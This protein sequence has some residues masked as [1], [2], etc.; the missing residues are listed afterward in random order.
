MFDFPFNKLK[1]SEIRTLF[2][3][4]LESENITKLNSSSDKGYK[5]I[6]PSKSIQKDYDQTRLSILTLN[7]RSLNANFHRLKLLLTKLGFNPTIIIVS[8]T[9]INDQK[10]FLYSLEN[11]IFINKPGGNRGGGAGIFLQK[12]LDYNT[13]ENLNLSVPNCEDLWIKLNLPLNKTLYI[14]SIYRHPSPDIKT[15]QDSL[16]DKINTLNNHNHNFI[17]GGDININFLSNKTQITS[18]KNH[19][20]SQGA[21]Q[22]AKLP[23]RVSRKSKTLID[24]IYTNIPEGKT[25]TDC[26]IF[27]ISDHLPLITYLKPYQSVKPIFK[28]KLI[29]DIKNINYEQFYTELN[30]N[31][32]ITP[33]NISTLS[34]NESWNLFEQIYTSTFDKHA[35]VRLQTRR[36][37]KKSSSPWI[38]KEILNSIK[39]RQKLYKKAILNSN[40]LNWSKFRSYRNELNRKILKSKQTY[41]KSEIIK[42]KTNSQK[43]WKTMNKIINIKKNNVHNEIKEILDE[44]NQTV[45]EPKKMSNIFNKYFTTIGSKLSQNITSNLNYTNPKHTKNKIRDS[46]YLSPMSPSEVKTYI[47]Q[48]NSNKATKSNSVPIKILKLTVD[49]V[50]PILS[51]IFN[52]CIY[53][54]VFPDMLKSA[55]VHPIYKKGSK[56]LTSNHRP[57]SIL[58]PFSK[59]FERHILNQLTNF[60]QKHKILHPF[61]YGFRTNSSTEMAVTQILEEITDKIQN[62]QFVCSVFL[63]LAK[64]FD[65]VDH[66]I[67]L[68][69]LYE[70]GVR[71]LPAELIKSYLTGRTQRTIVNNI[72]SDPSVVTCGVPQ[73]SIL[74]PLLFNLYINDIIEI[75]NFSIK[76]FADDACLL[77]S[78]DSPQQLEKLVNTE[79]SKINNWRK[80]NKLS[81]NFTKSDYIIFT[82]KKNNYKFN[83]KMDLNTLKR[84]T[85]TRYLG[86]IIDQKLK[87]NKHVNYIITKIT[88][89]SYI[90]TK[91]RHYINTDSIKLLYYSLIHPH[92]NYCLTAWGGAPPSTLQPLINFQKKII[93]IMSFSKFDHPSGPLFSKLGI[94]PLQ[95]L[96]N[97]N[98]SILMHK[99]HN[100]KITG[101][102]N[103]TPIDQIH[104]HNTRFSKNS[105]YY[106]TFN[107]LNLGLT[108]FSNQG[109][110]F[111]RTLP[112]DLKQLPLH[113]FKKKLKQTL[114][115]SLNEAIT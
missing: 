35:P 52:K 95:L 28:R 86:I 42:A 73:G 6:Y 100:N 105:N 51:T 38:T 64:A 46:F 82:N 68:G 110:K 19:I 104:S 99:T 72:T 87:W 31:L 32:N 3:N 39:T 2:L 77:C 114:I 65:T 57:I 83:I 27:D 41:F 18:Y 40:N 30:D 4:N 74:G 24:H 10:P 80:S 11:Y 112:L 29:R 53:E 109:A 47:L 70:Y 17:I 56:I 115:I 111:W 78:S 14:S 62:G 22:L 16:L 63:D 33:L 69:K 49:I 108:T 13:I 54:G 67:L 60:I 26:M 55:E 107:K 45:N 66:S 21:I 89:V 25:T 34:A 23:T 58:S 113:S 98:I 79:L 101:H 76:L 1:N 71:G 59:I 75:S 84:T 37:L 44:N 20:L 50:A 8:E 61:Q 93:R 81:V 15:F 92:L 48:L 103:L 97:L 5:Y 90:L 43:T 102:Y 12:N 85:E 88:K 94:L 36:E 96:Y 9:W 106:T 91:I 7:I